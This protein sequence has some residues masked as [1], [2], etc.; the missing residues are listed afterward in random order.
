ML[1]EYPFRGL[2]LSQPSQNLGVGFLTRADNVQL[3]AGDLKPAPA[4]VAQH[5]D[6]VGAAIYSLLP[7]EVSASSRAVMFSAASKLWKW[8]DGTS[9]NPTEIASGTVVASPAARLTS[10][11]NFAYLADGTNALRRVNLSSVAVASGLSAP[12]R[13]SAGRTSRTIGAAASS[14]TQAA[15]VT[16]TGLIP[17]ADMDFPTGTTFWTTAGSSASLGW[18]IAANGGS[19]VLLDRLNETVTT[20]SAVAVPSGCRVLR[21]ECEIAARNGQI[22]NPS[23]CVDVQVVAYSDAG[24]TTA[25]SGGTIVQRS[26]FAASSPTTKVKMVFDFRG[27]PTSV[28]SVRLSIIQPFERSDH[29]TTGKGTFVNRAKLFPAGQQFTFGGSVSVGQGTIGVK[30]S[31]LLCRDLLMLT[32][33]GTAQNLTGRNRLAVR[34]VPGK[35]VLGA[36]MR[37]VFYNGGSYGSG[38]TKVVSTALDWDIVAGIATAEIGAVAASLTDVRQWGIELTADVTIQDLALDGGQELFQVGA[39]SESGNLLSSAGYYYK[40]VQVDASGDSALFNVIQSDGSVPTDVVETTLAE[41]MVNVTIPSLA[42]SSYYFKLVRFGG[43]LAAGEG[44][45]VVYLQRSAST[46]AY[47]A[48]A[49]KGT[50]P[51]YAQTANPYIS[52]D[53]TGSIL[54]DN[55]PDAW[56]VDA[57]RYLSGRE[58]PPTAPT[59]ASAFASRVWLAKGQE[60]YASWSVTE[61]VNAGLYWTRVSQGATRDAE[62]RLKGWWKL[63]ALSAGDTIQRLIPMRSVLVVLTRKAIWVVSG[64]DPSNFDA[65]EVKATE[66]VGLFAPLAVTVVEDVL[67]FLSDDGLYTFDGARVRRVSDM[68]RGTEEDAGLVVAS[69]ASLT[70]AREKLYLCSNGETWVYHMPV[71]DAGRG[72]TRY[73]YGFSD[74]TRLGKEFLGADGG[75]LFKLTGN[76]STAAEVK[77]R[78]VGVGLK[79]LK[80]RW[81]R[82][83]IKSAGTETVTLSVGRS[84]GSLSESTKA[85]AVGENAL[86]LPALRAG[87][88][89][90]LQMGFKLTAA[91]DWTLRGLFAEVYEGVYER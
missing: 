11:A 15:G 9:G 6:S 69:T 90:R 31:T 73:L 8:T 7:F 82:T 21:F 45:V 53:A 66:Q 29:A 62:A 54:L 57:E 85:L 22:G 26:D 79:V 34:L 44:R 65:R 55:T 64:T 35:N 42:S 24:G 91:G 12:T 30:A 2:D 43:S 83:S 36:A 80:T 32:A 18:T 58:L 77:T 19:A 40:L 59:E 38:G 70:F 84:G 48:D 56:L 50:S 3:A 74:M 87:W 52:W 13:P 33:F 76:A 5:A 51:F 41:S 4:K 67:Y 25:I 86:R 60:L 39:L 28:A 10:L 17:A 1:K 61:D 47:G 88:A 23:E 20:A 68:I 71:E 63:L 75:R 14:W 89:S 78:T 81:L 16:T 49:A 27:L 46:F 72:W 37:L